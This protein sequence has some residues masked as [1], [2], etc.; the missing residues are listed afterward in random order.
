ML[1]L[2][3]FDVAQYVTQILKLQE[4]DV[5]VYL[6]YLQIYLDPLS[7]LYHVNK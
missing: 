2:I 4:V 6:I 5:H 7:F 3:T 1:Y